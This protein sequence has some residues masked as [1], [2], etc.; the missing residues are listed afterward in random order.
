MVDVNINPY[1]E[2]LEI[3]DFELNSLRDG[4]SYQEVVSIMEGIIPATQ[5][6]VDEATRLYEHLYGKDLSLCDV[7]HVLPIKI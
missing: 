3:G 6:E 4:I 1:L 5:E 7:S 2:S